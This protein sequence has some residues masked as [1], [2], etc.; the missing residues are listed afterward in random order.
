MIILHHT[1]KTA[2]SQQYRGSSDIAAAV[3]VA[4]TLEGAPKAGALHQLTLFSFKSRVRRRSELQHGVPGRQGFVAREVAEKVDASD[5]EAVI[6]QI[7]AA[8]PGLNG[9]AI[10]ARAKERGIAKNT[11]DGILMGVPSE[12]GSGRSK[13]YYPPAAPEAPPA[14][15]A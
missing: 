14:S 12:R 5:A 8:E 3:D 13:R 11:V 4:Y 6:A 7:I 10:K 15:P 2:S 9:M 1:G